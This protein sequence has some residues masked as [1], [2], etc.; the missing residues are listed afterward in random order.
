MAPAGSS[1]SPDVRWGSDRNT[2]AEVLVG[3]AVGDRYTLVN[4]LC[5]DINEAARCFG[6]ECIVTTNTAVNM[7]E[8]IVVVLRWDFCPTS[9]MRDVEGRSKK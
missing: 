8:R 9:V 4:L 5:R 3:V 7:T 6:E 2:A 1:S